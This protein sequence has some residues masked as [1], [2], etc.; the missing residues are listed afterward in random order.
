[1]AK[2]TD[3]ES[4]FLDHLAREAMVLEGEVPARN[5]MIER[6]L[7]CRDFLNLEIVRE[8]D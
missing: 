6:G 5:W 7:R 4:L 2:L 8:R 3:K 1:M